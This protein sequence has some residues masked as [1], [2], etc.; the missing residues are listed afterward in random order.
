MLGGNASLDQSQQTTESAM[1]LKIIGA[2]MAGLLAANMLRHH[3]PVVIESAP[4]LPNNHSAVLRFRSSV[5]SDVLGIPFRKVNMIKAHLPWMNAVAD[6]LSYAYKNTG[7]YRSDRSI[8]SSGIET[9]ERY[10]APVDLIEQMAKGLDIKFEQEWSFSNADERVLSTIP[11]P[12]LMQALAYPQKEQ[13][14]FNYRDGINIR[15]FVHNCDAYA[16]LMIPDP[17]Y[18]FSRVSITGQELIVEIPFQHKTDFNDN[19]GATHATQDKAMNLAKVAGSLLGLNVDDVSLPTWHRQ[20]YQKITPINDRQRQDF[21]YWAS[22]AT[23]RAFSLGR[24][25]T[26]RPGLMLDDLVQDIRLIDK[27][28]KLGN[29]AHYDQSIHRAKAHNTGEST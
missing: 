3:N 22:T 18:P 5:V 7:T 13:V 4:S 8:I 20:R 6:S 12:T 11:M 15:S 9:H 23:N 25:A 26:W 1:S 2:G 27:W 29:S 17:V 28:I 14:E 10:I 24:F 19:W 21:I 16:S